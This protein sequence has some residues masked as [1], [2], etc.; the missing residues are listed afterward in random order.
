MN[1]RELIALAGGAVTWPLVARAQQPL[2]PVI[3]YLQSGSAETSRPEVAAFNKGL[4]EIG[5]VDGQNVKIEYRWGRDQLDQLPRMAEELVRD[6]VQVIFT[7]GGV[8]PA[9]AARNATSTIPIVFTHGSDPIK[10]GLVASLNRPGGN[11]TGLSLFNGAITAKRLELLRE[12][13][14]KANVIAVLVNPKTAT[15][16]HASRTWS[17][18]RAFSGCNSVS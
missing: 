5:F 8:T 4:N 10:A 9:L 14:P 13:V 18:R 12:I 16:K 15:E 7:L 2:M 1:R 17:K 3:G 6:R 11:V